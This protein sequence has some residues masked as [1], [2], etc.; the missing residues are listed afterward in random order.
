MIRIPTDQI[1]CNEAKFSLRKRRLLAPPPSNAPLL[2]PRQCWIQQPQSLIRL[3]HGIGEHVQKSRVS[4][5]GVLCSCHLYLEIMTFVGLDLC[6]PVLSRNWA[7]E[8]FWFLLAHLHW[9]RIHCGCVKHSVCPTTKANQRTGHRSIPASC[10][11]LI[12]VG[13]GGVGNIVESFVCHYGLSLASHDS[14]NRCYAFFLFYIT[15][16]ADHSRQSTQNSAFSLAFDLT[17]RSTV[18]VL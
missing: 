17:L 13:G 1:R 15:K 16:K 4:T 7:L 12:P 8:V 3:P 18:S 5:N 11:E 9:I 10:V 6:L 14:Q 2:P